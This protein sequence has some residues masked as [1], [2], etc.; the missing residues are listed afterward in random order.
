MHHDQDLCYG[1]LDWFQSIACTILPDE[2][3][4]VIIIIFP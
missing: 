1:V 2:I 3:M 4:G